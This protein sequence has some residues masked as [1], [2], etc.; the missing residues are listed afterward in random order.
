MM[1]SYRGIIPIHCHL[2][3][4]YKLIS[5]VIFY[6]EITGARRNFRKRR[7][8][9]NA[10]YKEKKGRPHVEKDPQKAPH[11]EKGSMGGGAPTLASPCG[12]PCLKRAIRIL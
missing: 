5:A 9:I 8:P 4:Q 11:V 3:N 7:K 12:R 6:S 2:Y 10:P 1:Q